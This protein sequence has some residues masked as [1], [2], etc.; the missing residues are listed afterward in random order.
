MNYGEHGL[1]LNV[2]QHRDALFKALFPNSIAI[3][4]GAEIK[5][6]SKD[7][8]YPFRQNSDFYYLT[9]YPEPDALAVFIKEDNSNQNNIHNNSGKFILFN[10]SLD[11]KH[12]IWHGKLLGQEQAI[13]Q[14]GADEAYPIEQLEQILPQLLSG[15]EIISRRRSINRNG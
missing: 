10:K 2:K 6:R 9:A 4:P 11:L 13:Q 7:V 1:L 14:Y 15:K 12:Q 8:E 3:L 5:Y